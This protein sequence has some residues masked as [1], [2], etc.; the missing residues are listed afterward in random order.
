[1]ISTEPDLLEW[2]GLIFGVF[3][4]VAAAKEHFVCW[5]FSII[6][7][8]CIAIEDFTKT[9]LYFDG[10]L[11]IFYLAIAILGLISWYQQQN[12]NKG[13]F[14]SRLK[15]SSHITYLVFAV[16]ISAGSG[17][18]L[19]NATDAAMP[20]LDCFTTILSIIATF[21]LIYKIL[22]T[23]Y[24][25]AISNFTMIVLYYR[26][27]AVLFSALYLIF[28]VAVLYGLYSWSQTM[29]SGSLASNSK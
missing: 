11:H 21:L 4:I 7:T 26:Q 19:A 10:L 12:S 20:Y 15:A 25:F 24:Y 17:Y 18:I 9:K 28:F 27:S 14:V 2:I 16:L 22:D 29:K 23:W 3:Y 1:M 8:I 6:S 5:I 13:L